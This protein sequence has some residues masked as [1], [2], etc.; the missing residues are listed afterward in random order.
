M[1]LLPFEE[2]EE[3][4]LEQK[5]IFALRQDRVR[6]ALSGKETRVDR[7]LCPDWVNVVAFDDDDNLLLVRQW[8]FGVREFS[9][10]IPAGAIEAGEDPVEGGLRELVEET[11]FTPVDRAQVVLLGATRPNAAFMSN[12]CYSVLVPRARQTHP[13]KLDPTEEIEVLKMPRGAIDDAVKNGAL[14]CARR[15]SPTSADALL[16]NSLVVVALHLWTLHAART[17]VG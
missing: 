3:G 4:P 14:R 6:S 17:G 2:L 11:G 13:Q 12:R 1:T 5:R 8:R 15:T 9:I 10:E 16:D 7:L